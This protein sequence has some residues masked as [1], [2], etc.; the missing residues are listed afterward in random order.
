MYSGTSEAYGDM[1]TRQI[2]FGGCGFHDCSSYPYLDEDDNSVTYDKGC[3]MCKSYE[4]YYFYIK[5][6]EI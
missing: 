4:P 5:K 3:K 1:M 6:G 2:D